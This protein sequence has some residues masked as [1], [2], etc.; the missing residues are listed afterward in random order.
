MLSEVGVEVAESIEASGDRNG[1]NV[2]NTGE[3]VWTAFVDWR[4][5]FSWSFESPEMKAPFN[6][7]SLGSTTR[8][9]S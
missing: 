5:R 6:S 9:I 4:C 3:G 1:D 7:R 2:L 8:Q